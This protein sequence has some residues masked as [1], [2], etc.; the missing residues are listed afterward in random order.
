MI[1]LSD[2]ETLVCS[3][4]IEFNWVTSFSF[5]QNTLHDF[6]NTVLNFDK[7]HKKHTVMATGDTISYMEVL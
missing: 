3:G 1:Y 5:T 7:C 6:R 2:I 4:E